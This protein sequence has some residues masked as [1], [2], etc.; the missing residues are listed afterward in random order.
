MTMINNIVPMYIFIA[1]LSLKSS[2]TLNETILIFI[3]V[4]NSA[5]GFPFSIQ[6][7]SSSGVGLLP[8]SNVIAGRRVEMWLWGF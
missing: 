2:V 8:N 7:E 6:D 3:G 4:G 5:F 1:E